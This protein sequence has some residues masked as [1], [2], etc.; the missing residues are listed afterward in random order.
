MTFK[1][2]MKIVVNI[3]KDEI[4]CHIQSAFEDGFDCTKAIKDFHETNIMLS[5]CLAF[6]KQPKG[7]GDITRPR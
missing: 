4:S 1:A 7:Q 3:S 5:T 6:P 2:R